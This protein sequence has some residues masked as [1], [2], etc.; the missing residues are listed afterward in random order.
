MFCIVPKY[1]HIF[2]KQNNIKMKKLLFLPLVLTMSLGLQAQ[3]ED[4]MESIYREY[5]GNKFSL[6][7]NLG[8]DFLDNIDLDIDTDDLRQHVK[9]DVRRLRFIKFDDFRPALR[10]QKEIIQKLFNAGYEYVSVEDEWDIHEETQVLIFKKKASRKTPHL[11]VMINDRD[12]REA[13]LIIL[14]GELIFNVNEV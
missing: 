10:S 13:L 6:N 14:S 2:V 11:I 1:E 5:S 8:R 7:I 4:L 3:E 9:G 12:D